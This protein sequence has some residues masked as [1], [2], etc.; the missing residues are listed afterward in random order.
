MIV[1]A[2]VMCIG[3]SARPLRLLRREIANSVI[4]VPSEMCTGREMS[5]HTNTW[6]AHKFTF[7]NVFAHIS[8]MSV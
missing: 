8:Y 3:K 2:P 7:K 4:N 1:C 5:A 6:S